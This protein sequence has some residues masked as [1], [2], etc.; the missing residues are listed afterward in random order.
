MDD[1]A[2]AD[3][4]IDQME[5]ESDMWAEGV[6]LMA[7]IKHIAHIS[8]LAQTVPLASREK[9]IARQEALLDALMRQAFIEGAFRAVDY[10]KQRG[11]YSSEGGYNEGESSE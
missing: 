11:D 1:Q 6:N 2:R 7:S 9:M 10:I 4:A 3:M 5:A 8:R